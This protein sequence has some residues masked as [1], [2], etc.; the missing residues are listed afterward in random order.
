MANKTEVTQSAAF[1]RPALLE[2]SRDGKLPVPVGKYIWPGAALSLILATAWGANHVEDQVHDAAPNILAAAGID[3]TELEFDTNYRNVSVSGVVNANHSHRYVETVLASYRGTNGVNIRSATATAMKINERQ[4]AQAV[5]PTD[6]RVIAVVDHEALFLSGT[7]PTQEDIDKLLNAAEQS[8]LQIN[9]VNKLKASNKPAKN[10]GT[11]AAIDDL[12]LTISNFDID[13]V[14]AHIDI[15]NDLLTGSITS[16]GAL[17]A[18]KIRGYLPTTMIGVISDND[19][20]L[21]DETNLND[22]NELQTVPPVLPTVTYVTPESAPPLINQTELL[23]AEIDQL[24]NII[25]EQVKFKPGSSVLSSSTTMVLDRIV[26]ALYTHSAT[27]LEISG[28]TDSQSSADNNLTLSHQRAEAVAGYIATRGIDKAR[29]VAVGFGESHPIASNETT[30]G[31][32]LNR[33]VEFRA[34]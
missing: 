11:A 16:N 15:D 27:S 26:E 14:D 19:S 22:L 24:E 33:R 3:P 29:L 13:I 4:D 18:D 8:A 12:A 20:I 32:A 28:H 7:V 30:A 23:Q 9:I 17:A 6:V 2:G 5:E 34:L 10:N 25:R 21:I 1:T 31:R